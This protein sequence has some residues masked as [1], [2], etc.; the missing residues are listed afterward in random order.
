M[1]GFSFFFPEDIRILS[2]F[3]RRRLYPS[4][5]ATGE[6]NVLFFQADVTLMRV[7]ETLAGWTRASNV[8]E[9]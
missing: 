8:W 3:L 9:G 6:T 4:Y 1:F 2:C 7:S 5:F